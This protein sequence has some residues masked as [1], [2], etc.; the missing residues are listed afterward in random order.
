MKMQEA[1]GVIE[2][3]SGYIVHFERRHPVGLESDHFPEVR[4]GEPPIATEG[5]AWELARRFADASRGRYFNIYVCWA[6]DFTPVHGP[7]AMMYNPDHQR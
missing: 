3:R 7:W 6:S 1:L 2:T 4:V 5:R